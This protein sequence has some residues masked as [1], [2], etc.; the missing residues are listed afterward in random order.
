MEEGVLSSFS[1]GDLNINITTRMTSIEVKDI[2]SNCIIMKSLYSELINVRYYTVDI[3]IKSAAYIIA[4]LIS[5]Q[6]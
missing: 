4:L 1:L 2:I 5:I 3:L 6:F